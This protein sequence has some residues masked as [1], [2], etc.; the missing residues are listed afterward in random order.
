L[1]AWVHVHWIL[2]V[3]VQHI[4]HK[5]QWT[6]FDE[7]LLLRSS[8]TT[9]IRQVGYT[10]K[11]SYNDNWFVCDIGSNSAWTRLF[12]DS[13]SSGLQS[14]RVQWR[15]W[16]EPFL[17]SSV[18][19]VCLSS[20]PQWLR[21][22]FLFH[23]PERSVVPYNP[24]ATEFIFL[25]VRTSQVNRSTTVRE[26]VTRWT[27]WTPFTF[28]AVFAVSVWGSACCI[29]RFYK[30]RKAAILA[31]VNQLRSLSS[32]VSLYFLSLILQLFRIYPV[33]K[34]LLKEM[35]LKRDYIWLCEYTGDEGY[36][37]NAWFAIKCYLRWNTSISYNASWNVAGHFLCR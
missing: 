4:W 2:A 31:S 14:V 35:P 13:E 36:R 16:R 20:Y 18:K 32:M 19:R 10:L 17:L 37:E 33:L 12:V 9:E 27:C 15:V 25:D 1:L 21:C 28:A 5:N 8:E 23:A 24:P 6:A 3:P 29:T 30:S 7:V 34:H 11:I 22:R 26:N